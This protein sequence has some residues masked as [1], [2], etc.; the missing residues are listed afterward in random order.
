[1][2][3]QIRGRRTVATQAEVVKSSL[4]PDPDVRPTAAMT[5]DA[6]TLPAP[7]EVV[8]MTQHT[9]HRTVFVVRKIEDQPL[10]A[11]HERLAQSQSRATGQQCKQREQR[12]EHDCQY[13][14]RMPSEH[15]PAAESMRLLSGV[16]SGARTQ[17]REQHDP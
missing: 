9:A 13:Q 5:T 7:I 15:E 3:D 12:A 16:S 2:T 10:A 14:P 17:Q 8:V 1:V 4:G 11:A 6:R